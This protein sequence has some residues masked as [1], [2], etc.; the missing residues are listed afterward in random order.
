ME[1]S[2][3]R[4][5]LDVE[6]HR[7]REVASG[8]DLAADVPSCPDWT[9]ADLVRHVAEVYLHKA[10][11]IRFARE[12]DPWPPEGIEDEMPIALLDR[13]YAALAGELDTHS[14]TER[15]YTWYD[16][17]QS[18]G[19]WYRR[20]AHET[21]VHRVDAELAA[22]VP[23]TSIPDDLANDGVDE[24]LVVIAEFSTV[25]WPDYFSDALAGADRR[26]VRLSTPQRS[27]DV[28]MTRENVRVRESGP[29]EPTATVAGAPSD[30]LLWL[31]DRRPDAPV[32]QGDADTP[33]TLRRVLAIATR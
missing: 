32:P 15:S 24:I 13:A 19:F 26:T 4:G 12:P 11:C 21:V 33:D 14:P 27:W 5:D 25:Y 9:L 23:L 10:Q 20:M 28:L 30:V 2:E 3:L 18:V 29:G 22:G 1:Y 8:A 16:P 31:W 7:L 17:D 6:F